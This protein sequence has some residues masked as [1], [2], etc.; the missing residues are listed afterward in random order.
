MTI[1]TMMHCRDNE[2][3]LRAYRTVPKSAYADKKEYIVFG[4]K[5]SDGEITFFLTP[6]QFEA[7]QALEVEDLKIE[8]EEKQDEVKE[9]SDGN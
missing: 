4:V 7:I 2:I 3:E 5:T 8:D 6:A 1:T 9:F